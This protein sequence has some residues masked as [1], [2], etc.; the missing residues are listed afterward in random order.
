MIPAVIKMR[1]QNRSAQSCTELVALVGP[2]LQFKEIASIQ[3]VVAEKFEN[4]AVKLIRARL[5]GGI[6]DGAI[7][8]AE[9]GAIATG[10]DF[11]FLDGIHRRLDD[12]AGAVLQVGDIRVVVNTVYQIV[13]LIRSGT[14]RAESKGSF[15]A[16]GSEGAIPALSSANWLKLRPLRGRSLIIRLSMTW[17][18]SDVCVFSAG[19]SVDFHIL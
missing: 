9:L 16:P 2:T 8:P 10:L 1:N 3:F 6:E 19:N 5:D 12:I 4:A 13:I 17:P 14:V 11:E 15:A 18:R 7:P